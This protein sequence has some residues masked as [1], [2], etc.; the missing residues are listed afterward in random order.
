L[1]PEG[2]NEG[3]KVVAVE[4]YPGVPEDR[5]GNEEDKAAKQEARGEGRSH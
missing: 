3:R 1:R 4:Q 2:L 5:D